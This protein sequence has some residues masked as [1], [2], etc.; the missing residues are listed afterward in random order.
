MCF[1]R[2]KSKY[3]KKKT[4]EEFSRVFHVLLTII[5]DCGMSAI[6]NIICDCYPKYVIKI[7]LLDV[8]FNLLIAFSLI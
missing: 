1:V 5:F 2:S 6:P 3:I 7:L 4:L 8:C